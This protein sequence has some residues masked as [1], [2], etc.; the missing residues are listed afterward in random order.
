MH[1]AGFDGVQVHQTDGLAGIDVQHD[2]VDLGIAVDDA[3]LELPLPFGLLQDRGQGPA[4]FY[5]SQAI[6]NFR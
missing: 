3:L 6:F 5:K 1:Q 4:L 2:V